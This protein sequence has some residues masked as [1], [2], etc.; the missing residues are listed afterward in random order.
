MRPT[1]A[2]RLFGGWAALAL[3]ACSSSGGGSPGDGADADA[4][5]ETV[6][7]DDGNE[8]PVETVDVPGEEASGED[9]DA[10][11]DAAPPDRAL[12][13][14]PDGSGG[15]CSFEQPCSLVEARD[16]VRTMTATMTEDLVVRLRGGRYELAATFELT[17][18]LDSGRN[19][20]RVLWQTYTDKTPMLS[21]GHV[22]SN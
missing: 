13:V 22:L 7:P 8:A 16:K 3:A 5:D 6:A 14:A 21:N 9:A 1:L 10:P 2:L 12:Y 17:G 18:D 4:A 20:F 11:E 15:I 19:G